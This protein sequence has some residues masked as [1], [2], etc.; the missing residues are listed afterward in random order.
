[1]RESA[2]RTLVLLL[3]GLLVVAFLLLR[4][5]GDLADPKVL[6]TVIAGQILIAAISKYKQL[7]FL[8]VMISFLWAGLVVP[9]NEAWLQG[10]WIVLGIG[11]VVGVASYVRDRHQRHFGAIHLLALFCVLSAT[12][13]ASVSGYPEEAL[14][15]SL[16]LFLLFA[17][18]V[19]GARLTV[20]PFQP[21]KFFRKLLLAS[22]ITMYIAAFMYFVVRE[23]IFGNPNSL[24]AVMGVIVVP[25]LF[26][27]FLSAT[28]VAA[29]RR[30]GFEVCLAAALLMSSF[31][32][33]G[34]A[35]AAVSC[36]VVA[37]AVR[38]YRLIVSGVVA[39]VAIATLTVMFAPRPLEALQ[40]DRS[41][42][43]ASLFLYKG[44]PGE[45]LLGS[46]RRPWDETMEV[47]KRHPWF[48]SG[49]GTSVSGQ[50]AIDFEFTRSRFIE[51][52]MVREHG[53][54]YLAIM[55]WSG[56]LGVFP[57]YLLVAVTA[58][59]AK[60]AISQLRRSGNIWAP[61][62]PAAAVIIAGLIGAGFE[63]W[64]FAVGYYVSVFFWVMAFILAD[65]LP[66]VA[67][68]ACK[69]ALPADARFA[70]PVPAQ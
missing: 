7:Y 14:L 8:A 20:S 24:G 9:M 47:I 66:P 60:R 62:V 43:V 50:S 37:L 31:S 32:R 67:S 19:M 38:Q 26:W 49:F 68:T 4:R 64:L 6:G 3:A 27:G 29:R 45:G 56:L 16:S 39:I 28:A 61:S 57:F 69:S 54:S 65:L 15:K 1:M 2:A 35:A 41:E 40:D 22:E 53:N 21:E 33:A 42:S 25:V 70:V 34:I 46:R 11:V 18:G 52:R 59:Q 63:D 17:Y 36:F 44:K 55:E 10:R 51:S 23:P 5:P 12:V 48:G 30:I 58:W 13:S